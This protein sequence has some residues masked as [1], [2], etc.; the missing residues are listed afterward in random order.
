MLNK[1]IC[2][3]VPSTKDKSIPLSAEEHQHYARLIGQ[4]LSDLAGGATLTPGLIG[5]WGNIEEPITQV[6]CY[7]SDD[8]IVIKARE[9]ALWLKQELT[10]ESV[11][12]ETN[13][14]LDFI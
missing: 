14:G 6:K 12:F 4:K 1:Y 9:I 5:F 13:E 8:S 2:I 7:Y 11:S 3:Y 10:Q